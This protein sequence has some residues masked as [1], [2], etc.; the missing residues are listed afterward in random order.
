MTIKTVLSTWTQLST[1]NCAVKN[2]GTKKIFIGF[3]ASA[4]TGFTPE[5]C[6]ELD[7]NSQSSYVMDTG[8]WAISTKG[9]IEVTVQEF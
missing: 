3:G 9:G 4:P 1:G 7:G 2:F 5:Q 8:V 6:F